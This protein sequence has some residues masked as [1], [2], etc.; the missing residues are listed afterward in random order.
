ML[1]YQRV[2]PILCFQIEAKQL[3]RVK[4]VLPLQYH[5]LLSCAR[6]HSLIF[7]KKLTIWCCWGLLP[8]RPTLSQDSS[9]A[10]CQQPGDRTAPMIRYGVVSGTRARKISQYSAPAHPG[11]KMSNVR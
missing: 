2:W 6:S 1:N 4:P 3:S 10:P 5:Q 11:A 9:K 7:G 8:F